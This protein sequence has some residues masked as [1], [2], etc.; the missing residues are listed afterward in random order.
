MNQRSFIQSQ[1]IELDEL[2]SLA[3]NHPLMTPALRQK[4]QALEHDLQVLPPI[5]RE[6]RTVLFF[7][8][9][10]VVGSFGIDAAFASKVLDPFVEMVKTQYATSKHGNVGTRGRRR[11]ESEAK[12]LLTG[13][14]RGSFG[15]ELS[16]PD[17]PDLFASQQLTD[18][19]VHLTTLV[20]SAGESDEGFA[21]AME[22][23]SPRLLGRL[24]EFFKT[25]ADN[26]ADV[27]LVTGDI[28]CQL[29]NAKVIQA[30]DRVSGANTNEDNIEIRGVFRGAI[31]ESWR[32]D[33][34]SLSNETISGRLSEDLTE[35]D[36]LEMIKFTNKECTARLHTT[37]VTTRSGAARTRYELLHLTP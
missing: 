33:F 14:P 7:T 5:T 32:F 13:L 24:T 28:E 26:Q 19:L 8:G 34:R 18:S 15:L 23:A 12:L 1:L 2:L 6:P 10:P 11:D 25:I 4:R 22:D 21:V 35:D 27:R 36:V 17:A 30:Y 31:L 9:R 16:A 20:K 29:S 3:G 37:T